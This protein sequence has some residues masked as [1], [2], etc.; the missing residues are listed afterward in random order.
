M[1]S[2]T[3]KV[4][5]IGE[6][7]RGW[8]SQ[9]QH[10]KVFAA[11]THATYLLTEEEE[12]VWLGTAETPM[13]R[14][15]IQLPSP[16][17]R[18]A[19]GSTFAVKDHSI[20]LESG[21]NLDFRAS[22]IWETPAIPAGD[23]VESK[24]LPDKLHTFCDTFLAQKVP[25]GFGRLIQPV[26]QIAKK[27]DSSTGIQLENILTMSAWPIIER[28]ARA[29]L[30]H[31]LSGV[32]LQAEALIGL[33]EGL[34]PSGDDFLG[35]LFF[36]RYLLSC[37]YPQLIYLEFDNLPDRIDAFRP[38]TNLISFTLLKDNALGH[39]PDPLYRFG[40]ILL[41][42]QSIDCAVSAASEL[43]TLG[44]STGWD[45]LTG[46]LVGMLLT[47]TDKLYIPRS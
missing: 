30:S 26:I 16:L 6:A 46:F 45:L 18:L 12:L 31:D 40:I 34:T 35:G 20:E 47:F 2:C 38:S 22:K 4:H 37:S 11:V 28:V 29:C 24:L 1:D 17:P 9:G 25:V 41:S 36:A 44:H 3:N 21:T 8:L 39:A 43:T 19:V 23:L 14:R 33:G 7:A 10:G 32:L 13:H 15:C 5:I 27:Q 42:N